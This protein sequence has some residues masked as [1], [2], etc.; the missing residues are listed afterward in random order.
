[1]ENSIMERK[2]IQEILADLEKLKRDING[3][4]GLESL[5]MTHNAIV[6]L[7]AKYGNMVK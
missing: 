1:M 4:R 6:Q 7:E 5:F 2:L 3:F